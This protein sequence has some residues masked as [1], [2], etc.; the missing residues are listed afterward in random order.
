MKNIQDT[1]ASQYAN[2]PAILAIINGL[3]DI[4]DPSQ[5]IDDFYNKVWNITTAQGFGLDI[6]GR[7]VGISRTVKMTDPNQKYLGF[8][9]TPQTQD[10]SPFDEAP[11]NAAGASFDSYQLPDDTFR[12]LIIFK[13]AANII[14]AT[15]P[16]INKFL[17]MIFNDKA[18]YLVR[19]SMVGQYTFAF[20]LTP[21]QDLIVHSLN[22]LPEPSGV[23]VYYYEIIENS[24][25]GFYGTELQPFGYGVFA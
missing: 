6:W 25:F 16:N 18:F 2:S 15:A 14:Y 24:T 17:K 23:L 11:M 5:T 21:I 9:T 1:I 22:L 3:N 12:Q 19:G 10:F 13:A 7:I 4:I 8:Q 20:E